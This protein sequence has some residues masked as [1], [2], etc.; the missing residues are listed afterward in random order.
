MKSEK[1]ITFFMLVTDYDIYIA[2]YSVAS[3]DLLFKE[4]KKSY[5]PDF[6]LHV[7]A[8]NI[9]QANKFY[10][11]K[12][13]MYPF[14]VIFDNIQKISNQNFKSTDLLISPEGIERPRE[15]I[16]ESC[17]EVWTSEISKFN[18]KY[19]ATV[20]AD[21]EILNPRFI[22]KMFQDLEKNSNIAVYSSDYDETRVVFDTYL[23]ETMVLSQRW[24]TWFCIYRKSTYTN[25]RSHYF[26]RFL[27]PNNMSFVYDSGAY[28][29]DLLNKQNE[30]A[31][32]T[33]YKFQQDFIHY[34]AFA[35]NKNLDHVSTGI[36]RKLAIFSKNGFFRTQ[37]LP[38][39]IIN[40]CIKKI[41]FLLL[42]LKFQS[43]INERKYHH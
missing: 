4:H 2:D 10:L 12:W 25:D 20:D 33:D 5:F 18:T 8:N 42:K 34:G 31:Y 11:K 21:F 13:L 37:L 36:Y 7:Y 32:L 38:I 39:K 19:I 40:Y 24:H 30:M 15:G 14:V 26:Y 9:S 28:L 23:D 22:V 16:F 27:M 43:E 17:D 6:T 35:K 3:Y 1:K 41:A 29:Q